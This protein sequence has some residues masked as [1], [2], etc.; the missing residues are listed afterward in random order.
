MKILAFGIEEIPFILRN[1]SRSVFL[2]QT[3]TYN[4]FDKVFAISVMTEIGPKHFLVHESGEGVKTFFI[5]NS[6]GIRYKVRP[7]NLTS[8]NGMIVYS[9]PLAIYGVRTRALTNPA[10]VK[11]ESLLT[12]IRDR[13]FGLNSRDEKREI[14]NRIFGGR[15]KD[16]IDEKIEVLDAKVVT[17]I[18][19]EDRPKTGIR[20]GPRINPT[21]DF[22]GIPTVAV[23][24]NAVMTLRTSSGNIVHLVEPEEYGRATYA[25][26]DRE[27]AFKWA[28]REVLAREAKPEACLWAQHRPGHWDSKVRDFLASL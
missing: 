7:A 3:Q 22:D 19:P 9:I 17:E 4:L 20:R 23:G 25:F 2:K 8:H 26:H 27:L 16:L 12:W 14:F 10:E 15:I 5:T 18:D 1:R 21:N 11:D 28:R 24:R 6:R 13:F